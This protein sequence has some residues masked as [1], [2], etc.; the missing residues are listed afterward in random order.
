M[1]KLQRD[2]GAGRVKIS[3]VAK[4]AGVHTSTV[5][6]VLNAK[7]FGRISPEVVDRVVEIARGLGYRPNAV[8]AGLRTNS[9]GTVGFI[10]HDIDD[11]IYPPILK[12]IEEALGE[13]GLMVLLG[14]AGYAPEAEAE[15]LE[16]MAARRIDGVVLA[17]AR[18]RDPLVDRCLDYSL[19]TVA[20]VRRPELTVINSV[21]NDCALGMREIV[22]LVV[23][24]GHRDIAHIAGPQGL[25][26]GR[27]RFRG[28]SDAMSKAGL[29]PDLRHLRFVDQ[30]TIEAGHAAAGAILDEGEPR[31]S[32]IVCVNDLVA[33]G[34]I[35]ACRKKGF[36]CPGDISITGYNDIPLAGLLNPPL[37][38]V[39][40]RLQEIGRRTGLRMLALLSDNNSE[41]AVER[42][43]PELTLRQS[44][45]RIS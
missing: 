35:N 18:L 44:V 25:S 1:N 3:D 40:M 38:T 30:P 43:R 16:R 37:T 33:I 39:H 29:V 9:T 17:T 28:F 41:I 10:V 5:S 14:N 7:T 24:Y 34:A 2:R 11:P 20:V 31:P 32:V 6:R 19:P 23:S 13:S 8:A 22:D 27:E 15:L 36:D 21:V 26:T 45:A 42:V 12:G 4:A